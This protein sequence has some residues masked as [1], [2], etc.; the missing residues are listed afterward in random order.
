LAEFLK[1]VKSRVPDKTDISILLA[2]DVSY[3]TLVT[4]MDTARSYQTVVVASVVEA[5]LFPDISIGDAPKLV[6]P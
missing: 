2:P 5:E 4:A 6:K 1:E 3:Q